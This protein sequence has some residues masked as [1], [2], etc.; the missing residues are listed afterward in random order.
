MCGKKRA[1]FGS[2]SIEDIED[3]QCNIIQ[4]HKSERIE[5]EMMIEKKAILNATTIKSQRVRRK[6]LYRN[7]SKCVSEVNEKEIDA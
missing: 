4:M 3:V 1:C 6:Y 7:M 5:R 2:H